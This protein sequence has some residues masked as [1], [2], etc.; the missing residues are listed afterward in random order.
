MVLPVQVLIQGRTRVNSF[1]FH[2]RATSAYNS[3]RQTGMFTPNP[4]KPGPLIR[5]LVNRINRWRRHP[6]RSVKEEMLQAWKQGKLVKLDGDPVPVNIKSTQ[7]LSDIMA[8][9]YEDHL[10]RLNQKE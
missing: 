6:R 3:V 2:R 4:S 9:I 1:H 8:D 10:E 5:D 7:E